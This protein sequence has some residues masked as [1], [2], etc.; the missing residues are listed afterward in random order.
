VLVIGLWLDHS[1]TKW[2]FAP[3][4]GKPMVRNFI[5]FHTFYCVKMLANFCQKIEKFEER[6]MSKKKKNA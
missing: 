1:F 3:R 4:S 6:K 5:Q 2:G